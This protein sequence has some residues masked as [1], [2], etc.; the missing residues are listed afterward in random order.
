MKAL[1]QVVFGY[2]GCDKNVAE[3][4]VLGRDSLHP[5]DNSWDWLGSGAYFWESAPE[6]AMDW[7]KK[8]CQDPA[9]LGAVIDLGHCMNLMDIGEQSVLQQAYGALQGQVSSVCNKGKNHGLDCYVVNKVCEFAEKDGASYDSVRGA[10]PEGD[11]IFTDSKILTLTH[12]QIC[13]R[14]LDSIVA[15][16]LPTG[17]N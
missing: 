2:H 9:V 3:K 16:F 6:R 12:V 7:A 4:I 17:L 8:H 13:V 1:S 14:N 10:F 15:Y 5:S 11:P